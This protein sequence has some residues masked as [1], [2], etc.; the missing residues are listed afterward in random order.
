MYVLLL[1]VLFPLNLL[2][3]P[4]A[5]YTVAYLAAAWHTFVIFLMIHHLC[6]GMS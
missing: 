3:G 2:T 6:Y 1:G 4:H 5:A